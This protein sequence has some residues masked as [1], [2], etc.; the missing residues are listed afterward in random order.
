MS[1]DVWY[2]R[3]KRYEIRYFFLLSFYITYF[4][5]QV[6]FKYKFLVKPVHVIA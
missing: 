4:L 6:H 1:E 2:R 5:I 3:F